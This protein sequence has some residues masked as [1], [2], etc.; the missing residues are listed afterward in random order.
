MALQIP[1]VT[2]SPG[3]W[4]QNAT[5]PA[6]RFNRNAQKSHAIVRTLP[7]T[8]IARGYMLLHLLLTRFRFD[9]DLRTPTR[10]V[11]LRARTYIQCTRIY[12][13]CAHS[14][15]PLHR[16]AARLAVAIRRFDNT[17]A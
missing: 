8:Q 1:L 13:E 4:R 3:N 5:A 2:D 7:L 12:T 16:N 11:A 9:P 17:V 10:G 6:T 14:Y 15:K